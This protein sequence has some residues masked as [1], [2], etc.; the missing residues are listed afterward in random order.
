MTDLCL[1]QSATGATDCIRPAGHPGLHRTITGEQYDPTRADRAGST[2][3][4]EVPLDQTEQA[5]AA[6]ARFE[7]FF[8]MN[9]PR[10]WDPKPD[11]ALVRTALAEL[12]DLRTGPT[13]TRE[14]VSE[15]VAMD[16]QLESEFGHGHP[17]TPLIARLRALDEQTESWG[18]RW[19][20]GSVLQLTEEVAR[21][22]H[23]S[24]GWGT[25]RLVHRLTDDDE[26]EETT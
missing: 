6:V 17:P 18:I 13:L 2:D 26:W 1:I 25:G 10:V 19:P 5:L 21:A 20:S 11:L 12:A 24:A 8:A 3:R 4:N 9:P 15:V 14:E 16:Y 23:G 7:L 22:R